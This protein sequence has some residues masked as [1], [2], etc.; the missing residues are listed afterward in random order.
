MHSRS[1]VYVASIH[2]TIVFNLCLKGQD[3]W[4]QLT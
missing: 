3:K 4:L 2:N 1:I